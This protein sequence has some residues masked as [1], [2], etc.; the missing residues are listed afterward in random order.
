MISGPH[1]VARTLAALTAVLAVALAVASCATEPKPRASTRPTTRPDPSPTATATGDP[2]NS[3]EQIDADAQQLVDR[4][5]TWHAPTHLLVDTPTRVGL[6]IGTGTQ[7]SNEVNAL[8]QS[9]DPRDAGTVQIGATV[10]ATLEADA[11]DATITPSVAVDAST[12]SDVELLWTWTVRAKHPSTDLLL[13]V[14]L[15]IPLADGHDLTRDLPLDISV[16]RTISYTVREIFNS[17]GTW[18]AIGGTIVAVGGWWAARRRKHR[19]TGG[20]DGSGRR[21]RSPAPKQRKPAMR[22]AST[23]FGQPPA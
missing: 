1:R 6:S 3:F 12:G 4:V 13:T 11:D 20:G 8:V 17:W 23:G 22:G 18:S 5:A 21:P 2:E 9:D 7:I 10:T 19:R 14:H 16:S 15:E